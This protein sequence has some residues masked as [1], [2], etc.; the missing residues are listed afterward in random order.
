MLKLNNMGLL[1]KL[2]VDKTIRGN[3]MWAADAYDYA[4]QEPERTGR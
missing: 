3:I 1:D 2:L 4:G